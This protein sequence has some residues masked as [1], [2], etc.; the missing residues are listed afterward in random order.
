M[1]KRVMKFVISFLCQF[2]AVWKCM[3]ITELLW[4]TLAACKSISLNLR[5]ILLPPMLTS[6]CKVW[7]LDSEL[8][9]QVVVW[10][11]GVVFY[12]MGKTM[13]RPEI[14]PDFDF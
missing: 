1:D 5:C 12:M 13:N 9:I 6:Y 4:Q 8:R 3:P 11:C 7:K 14:V 10:L 2:L